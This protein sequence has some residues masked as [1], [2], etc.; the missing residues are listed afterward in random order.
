MSLHS[1]N[2]FSLMTQGL[3]LDYWD[4]I[5]DDGP[6]IGIWSSGNRKYFEFQ[7]TG[8]EFGPQ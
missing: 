8:T 3:I 4:H 7:W 1:G 6:L 5:T 2:G